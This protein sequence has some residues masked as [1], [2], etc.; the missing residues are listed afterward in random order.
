[1]WPTMG[2]KDGVEGPQAED[3][4]AVVIPVLDDR[5]GLARTLQALAAQTQL[6]DE[7]I[8]VDGGSVDGT[9]QLASGWG[10]PR[11]AVRVVSAPGTSIGAARNAGVQAARHTWIACTDAGCL[12]LPGWLAAIDGRRRDCDFVAG[13]VEV[14]ARNQLQKVLAVTHY[15]SPDELDERRRWVRASHRIFGRGYV[16]DRVGGGSMA[17]SAAA[18]RAA[19]GLP[20]DHAAGEDRGFL[21]AVI[22]AGLRTVRVREA[23][24]LWEPP[25]T[26]WG[27]A[28]QF[29]RYARGDVRLRGRGRHVLRACAWI[30]APVAVLRGGAVTRLACVAGGLTY[31]ALP[32]RRSLDAGLPVSQW[33]WRIPLVAVLKDVAQLSGAA[34]GVLDAMRAAPAAHAAPATPAAQREPR[35][36]RAGRGEP[37]QTR[38][39]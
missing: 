29:H 1:M 6:P 34:A 31:L 36:F 24:V 16:V 5:S 23:A 3:G 14:H 27:N 8:V 32:I 37:G 21:I 11:L 20:E 15:P 18:W 25:A 12:A 10:D 39:A 9:V 22:A 4:I 35:P 13:V 2:S 7:V 17:F 28:R 38:S 33:W 19:G 30:C 26:W